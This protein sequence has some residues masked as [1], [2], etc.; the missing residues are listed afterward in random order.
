MEA[1]VFEASTGSPRPILQFLVNGKTI[2][3]LQGFATALS[4]GLSSVDISYARRSAIEGRS[5][6]LKP[7]GNRTIPWSN[8][9]NVFTNVS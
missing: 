5:F 3:I 6:E 7:L 9:G 8:R 1:Y 4:D 2:S